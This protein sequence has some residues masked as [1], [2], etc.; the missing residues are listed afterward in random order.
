MTLQKLMMCGMKSDTGTALALIWL[1]FVS[2]TA[3]A[4]D[5]KTD[6]TALP[7][8]WY[9]PGIVEDEEGTRVAG[10][11]VETLPAREHAQSAVTDSNGR[12]VFNFRSASQYGSPMVVRSSDGSRK[13]FVP[14][15]D[16]WTRKL[17][18][19]VLKPVRRVSVVVVDDSGNVQPGA[20]IG[21]VADMR[22]L[23]S[24]TAGD[25]GRAG[26]DLPADAQIDWVFA[27]LAGKGFDYYENYDAFPT[28]ERLTPPEEITLTLNGS[29]SADVIVVDSKKQP[30]SGVRVTPWII[31]KTGKLS[32]INLSGMPDVAIS[33]DSGIAAVPWLPIDLARNVAFIIHHPKYHCPQ[34]PYFESEA[35]DLTAHVLRVATIRGMVTRTDG[36]PVAGVHL[37]GEGR[38]NTNRYFRGHTM[39][40][41]DGTYEIDVYPDQSTIIAVTDNAH[42]AESRMDILLKEGESLDDADFVVSEGTLIH[43]TITLGKDREPVVGDNAT[44]LQSSGGTDLVRWSFTDE[45][46]RYRFRVGP[47]N[48]TLR[49]PNSESRPEIAVRVTNEAE[50]VH[51]GHSDRKDRVTLTGAAVG[52]DGEPLA[53]CE[54]HGESIAALG[55]AGF[56]TKT[57]ADG[58][59]STE[60]WSDRMVVYALHSEKGLAGFVRITEDTADVTLT[61]VPAGSA[62]GRIVDD[63][64]K[65]VAAAR[66]VLNVEV[67]LPEA[68]NGISLTTLSDENGNYSFD[69]IALGSS[70]SIYVYRNNEQTAGPSFNV[71]NAEAI[72]LDDVVANEAAKT[73]E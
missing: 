48:Y 54:V 13:S 44:L 43:G 61:L 21:V 51:D 14:Q 36:T 22:L 69:G 49:L 16:H 27:R 59:F 35:S 66:V 31:Q 58:R 28:Q 55:H 20:T 60:R 62:T 10:A 37:Q 39:T 34:P 53:G 11:I 7:F 63:Q 56:R 73:H 5:E 40:R 38:G 72:V 65:P 9:I 46:G 15:P 70:C 17:T 57:G 67:D 29:Q 30:V 23:D 33:D 32:Y 64:G 26:F 18:R 8:E 68:G 71:K 24:A 41:K 50:I 12:F 25:D 1:I 45:K 52:E 6:D 4:L 19:V 2:S 47:G 42:A 3:L